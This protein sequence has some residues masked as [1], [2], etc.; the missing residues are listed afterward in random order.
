MLRAYQR[1][2]VTKLQT[3]TCASTAQ[4]QRAG[5][6]DG[7]LR[8]LPGAHSLEQQTVTSQHYEPVTHCSDD[9]FSFCR[10]ASS[11]SA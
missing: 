8:M 4:M 9:I 7:L 6:K 3:A 1:L 2:C 11:T 5:M 10:R